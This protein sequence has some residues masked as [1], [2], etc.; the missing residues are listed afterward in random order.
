M[1]QL[2]EATNVPDWIAILNRLLTSR[3]QAFIALDADLLNHATANNRET[4]R[5]MLDLLRTELPGNIK[6]VVAV[7]SVGWTYVEEL[8]H[9]NACIKIRTGNLDRIQPRKRRRAEERLKG[10]MARSSTLRP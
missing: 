4:A 6:I 2:R 7:S 1:E 5:E 9:D 3:T 10:R 8:K